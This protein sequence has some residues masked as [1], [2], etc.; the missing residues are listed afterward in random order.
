MS[1]ADGATLLDCFAKHESEQRDTVYLIQPLPDGSVVN[2]TW[3]EVGDQARRMA[4]YFRAQG[5]SKGSRIALLGKNSAY[6]IIADLAILMADMVSVPLFPMYSGASARYALEHSEAELLILGKLDG[7]NDSWPDIQQNLPAGLPMLGLPLSPSLAIPQWLQV[8]AQHA[9][10]R[11]LPQLQRSQLSTIVYTSGSTGVPKGVMHTHGS[12]AATVR[13]IQRGGWWK[14][15]PQDRGF[16]YLPLAHVAERIGVE[17][18]S[19]AFGYPLYFAVSQDT[20]VED[21]QRARPTIFFSVPRLWTKFYLGVNEKLPPAKQKLLFALPLVSGLVKKKVL[22]LLGL[23][24][25][26]IAMTGSA[27]LPAP[28]I[29]WYRGLGL[30]LL[31]IY[32]MSENAAISHATRPGH[33]R[34]GTVGQPHPGVEAR[35]APSGELEVKSPAQMLG[36]Y[37]QREL[38]AD[39][40]TPDGFLR[41]GDCGEIDGDGYLRITGRIKDNF[42]TSGGKYVAPVPIEARLFDHPRF[43]A[44]CVVGSEQPAPFALLLLSADTSAALKSGV[45]SRTTLATELETLRRKVNA[46]AEHHEQLQYLVVVKDGWSVE[47]AMLTPTLKIRRSVIEQHYLPSA[48][49]WAASKQAVIWEGA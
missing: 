33:P 42:K 19:I 2:Y 1:I 20:F 5:L 8:Q 15:T 29:R 34:A 22:R 36:Y 6:W 28:L 49:Q 46:S 39:S 21:L 45:L 37:K 11:A 18:S 32:G 14:A 13:C 44:V 26:R 12:L 9:P 24:Q 43:E 40:V 25:V 47:N 35:I 16:S 27:P 41:T 7:N 30:E 38:S 23:D 17:S 31:D 48:P 4:A 3:G 10:L